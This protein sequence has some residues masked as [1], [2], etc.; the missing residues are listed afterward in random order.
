MFHFFIKTVLILQTNSNDLFGSYWGVTVKKIY[1]LGLV[2]N[3]YHKTL[4]V[5]LQSQCC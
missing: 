4:F 1:E 5:F 2:G 3:A